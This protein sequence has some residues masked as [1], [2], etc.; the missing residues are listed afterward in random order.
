MSLE[1]GALIQGK[2]RFAGLWVRFLALFIDLLLFATVFFPVTRLV[3]GVGIMSA[4]DHRWAHGLL[5]TDPLCMAFLGFMILG[6]VVLEGLGGVTFGKWI[7]GLR[8]RGTEGDTPGLTRGLVRNVLRIVDGLS[9]C[10]I[11]G[12][13]LMAASAEKARFGDRVAGTRVIHVR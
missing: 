6:F 3:K 4:E 5:V 8:V 2:V 9:V 12:I 13:V 11:L 1:N 10:N 7:V